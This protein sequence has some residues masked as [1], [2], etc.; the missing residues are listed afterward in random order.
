MK[1][2]CIKDNARSSVND[3]RE[4]NRAITIPSFAVDRR[5]KKKKKMMNNR[6][7]FNFPT[8]AVRVYFTIFESIIVC[9]STRRVCCV[10]EKA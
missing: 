9:R 3:F 4:R 10:S 7:S 2:W 1:I 5:R 8:I 6:R